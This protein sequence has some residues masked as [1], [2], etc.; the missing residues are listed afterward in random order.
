MNMST[1]FLHYAPKDTVTDNLAYNQQSEVP[2]VLQPDGS[3]RYP[4]VDSTGPQ[5]S[6]QE[7]VPG[8]QRSIFIV[9]VRRDAL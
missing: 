2:E 3:Y 8:F 4:W 5:P 7:A 9:D 6:D 1:S